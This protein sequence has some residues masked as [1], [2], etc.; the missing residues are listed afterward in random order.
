MKVKQK[1]IGEVDSQFEPLTEE[2]IDAII[3]GATSV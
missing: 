3:N 1:K 2:K